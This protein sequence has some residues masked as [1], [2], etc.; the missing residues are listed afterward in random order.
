MKLQLVPYRTAIKIKR[1]LAVARGGY[2]VNFGRIARTLEYKDPQVSMLFTFDISADKTLLL[3]HF[4]PESEQLA[5]Y[6]IAFQR[7]KKYLESCGYRVT[8]DG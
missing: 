5:Y 3:E 2:F 7:T 8:T 4:Q 1:F 6:D